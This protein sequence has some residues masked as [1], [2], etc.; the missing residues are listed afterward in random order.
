M[1]CPQRVN[2]DVVVNSNM[3]GSKP[4]GQIVVRTTP[5]QAFYFRPFQYSRPW[6][7]YRPIYSYTDRDCPVSIALTE[8]QMTALRAGQ[9]ISVIARNTCGQMVRVTIFQ[10]PSV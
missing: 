2:S 5:Q 4:L 9:T 10:P 6:W 7:Y 1:A 3:S 8:D